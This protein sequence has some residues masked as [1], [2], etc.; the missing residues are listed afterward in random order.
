[1]LAVAR[2]RCASCHGVEHGDDYSSNPLAPTFERIADTPGMTTTALSAA[3]RSS[4][5]VMPNLIVSAEEIA[6]L[7]ADLATRKDRE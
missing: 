2:E 6:A 1:M 4:H 3:L 5:T 7:S